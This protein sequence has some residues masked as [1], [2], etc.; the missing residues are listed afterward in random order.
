MSLLAIET[1]CDETAAAVL[2]NG[3]APHVAD[4]NGHKKGAA[5]GDGR[6]L[7][8]SIVASQIPLH[9]EHGGVVPELAAR[10]HLEALAPTVDAA[11]A[12][13]EGGWDAID[14]IAVTRG[15]GLAGCLLVGSTYAQ[16]VALA[17]GLPIVG[18]SHL[19]GHVYSAWLADSEL[20]PPFVALVVS[21][22]HTDCIELREHG[23]AVHLAATRDD[24]VGEAFDKV[25]RMLG[26]PYPG[27]PAIEKA[28][29]GGDPHRFSLPVTRLEDGFSFSGLKTA[30]RYLVRDLGPAALDSRGVP[31]SPDVVWDLAAAFQQAAITQLI[32]GLEAI[33][34][35]LGVE[36]IAV[37]GGVAAN[38]ALR[39]AVAEHFQ[40]LK[41]S[42]PPMSLCTDN[43]A[44]I[45]AAGWHR[46]RLHGP[47]APGFDVDPGLLE[48]A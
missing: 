31:A 1:S 22:G 39:S 32:N 43:A 29:R 46:L 10:A 25:A 33:V 19:A 2:G 9:A 28:A 18:V 35:R 26:L 37:V 14:A 30:V 41:I 23:N 4:S 48:F 44:M 42:V 24:A 40:G 3:D 36:Q 7:L 13:V 8:S 6:N 16:S 11:L 38:Q 34:D 21:G 27:G 5:A 47:D 17:R 20:E 12:K 45:A 15:P